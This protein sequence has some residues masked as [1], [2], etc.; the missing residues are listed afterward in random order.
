MAETAKTDIEGLTA[1]VCDFADGL[2]A[3]GVALLVAH[4]E[5]VHAALAVVANGL[6]TGLFSPH[7]ETISGGKAKM[8]SAKEAERRLAKH[9]NARGTQRLLTSE[10]IAT[11]L[12]LKTRQ[13]VHDWRK[14]GKLIG[15]QG[16]KRG[17]VYPAA[18]VN[19]QGH[20]PQGLASILERFPDA[21]SA[22]QW[23]TTPNPA[24]NG[25]KP[26]TAL[27]RGK[28]STAIDAAEGYSQGDF[29]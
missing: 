29:M 27:R 9:T 16:A 17:Y 24:L 1:L 25:E 22:W 15:W 6:S 10:E 19:D 28:V 7:V 26:L 21:Y 14:Q 12:G 2:D 5:A 4:P 8:V 20:P 13:S 18:Q 3:G 11:R 23:L